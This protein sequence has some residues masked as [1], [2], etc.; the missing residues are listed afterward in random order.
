MAWRYRTVSSK[1]L[2]YDVADGLLDRDGGLTLAIDQ[3]RRLADSPRV[4]VV[5]P[6]FSR[7]ISII[8]EPGARMGGREIAPSTYQQH[9][10]D[11]G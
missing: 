4:L 6:W 3:P 10:T 2:L 11:L 8:D 5:S 9:T 1:V 7:W